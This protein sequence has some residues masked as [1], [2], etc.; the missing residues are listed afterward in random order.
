MCAPPMQVGEFSGHFGG[1]DGVIT[2]RE[3]PRELQFHWELSGSPRFD[4]L[5]SPEFHQ[6]HSGSAQPISEER[7]LE[8][9]SALRRWLASQKLRSNID[10]PHDTSEGG[11]RCIWAGCE[12]RRLK[13]YY[14][15]RHH[16]DLS[17]LV[18]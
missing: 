18:R 6:W 16:F 9:L 5:V 11:E 7:Q 12:R 4:V 15:C 8:M 13:Q 17:C 3:P 10:L 1:R 2:Y 14:Y